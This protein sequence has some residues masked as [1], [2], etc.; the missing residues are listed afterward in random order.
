MPA[1]VPRNRAIRPVAP[2]TIPR[3]TPQKT[4]E[5]AMLETMAFVVNVPLTV[6]IRSAR[7]RVKVKMVL[8]MS[9]VAILPRF[10]SPH[11]IPYSG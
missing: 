10:S 8:A 6:A 4:V 3:K 5:W 7:N 11:R 9:I 1:P 2:R